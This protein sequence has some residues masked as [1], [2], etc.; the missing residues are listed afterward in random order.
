MMDIHVIVE[1]DGDGGQFMLAAFVGEA[2][3]LA[4][5][6]TLAAAL[7]P[8]GY[9]REYDT[10]LT[11]EGWPTYTLDH[12]ESVLDLSLVPALQHSRTAV[13]S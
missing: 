8:C 5:F 13:P 6:D 4:E 3:A 2:T 11:C 10:M 7:R 12:V 1:S 9:R